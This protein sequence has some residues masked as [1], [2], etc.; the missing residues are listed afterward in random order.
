MERR[1]FLKAGLFGGVLLAAGRLA[2]GPVGGSQPA[3]SPHRHFSAASASALHAIAAVM[4]APMLPT[5]SAAHARALDQCVAGIDT[6]IGGL[7]PSIQKEF[8]ELLQLLEN[9]IARRWLIGVMPD[10]QSATPEQVGHFLNRWRWSSLK[11]LRSGYQGLHQMVFA[12]W[13][14]Q[15][16]NWQGIRYPGPPAFMKDFWHA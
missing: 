5:E 8:A 11:L 13:Y 2:W 3:G 9:P 10:W 14:G 6:V 1:Q 4:L 15:A 12:A 16:E 7:Q